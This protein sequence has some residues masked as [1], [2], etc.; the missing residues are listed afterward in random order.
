YASK[1]FATDEDNG[2]RPPTVNIVEFHVGQGHNASNKIE[3]DKIKYINNSEEAP[4]F[5]INQ[6]L[7]QNELIIF[8]ADRPINQNI[9]LIPFFGKLA[10]IDIAAFKIALAKK[11]PISFSFG[12]K[13][14]GNDYHLYIS[15]PLW[16]EDFLSQG[17]HEAIIALAMKYTSALEHYLMM[18]PNQ[19]FNFYPFWSASPQN[20]SEYS[21][22]SKSHSI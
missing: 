14:G 21:K 10:P 2:V 22:G 16:P 19:W 7:N 6:A 18:Y 17:K 5:K 13:G 20:L 8:M 3:D 11:A 9:E 4:I 1:V 12:F 15:P